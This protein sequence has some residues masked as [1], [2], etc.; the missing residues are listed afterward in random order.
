M[1]ADILISDRGRAVLNRDG[2][3]VYLS[4]LIFV[5]V[6]FK[7]WENCSGGDEWKQL[8]GWVCPDNSWEE[9]YL[10]TDWSS[11]GGQHLKFG[12][13]LRR[14]SRMHCSCLL[15]K[16]TCA[17]HSG[18]WGSCGG[19]ALDISFNPGPIRLLG[20]EGTS[21]GV[22]AISFCSKEGQHW[23]QTRL[24]RALSSQGLK[25]S[26]DGPCTTFQRYL[27]HREPPR[28][29]SGLRDVVHV[30]ATD[31]SDCFESSCHICHSQAWG[32][33]SHCFF[34]SHAFMLLFLPR[35][36]GISHPTSIL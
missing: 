15:E 19:V 11:C 18:S 23:A 34:I 5:N 20:W 16:P 1:L 6:F 27:W 31:L 30:S 33:S 26:E 12:V 24:L 28:V 35:T 21:G 8:I 22:C 2:G 32:S 29:R 13:T 14:A 10:L 25:T 3:C 36:F 7:W 9:N 4:F 17:C